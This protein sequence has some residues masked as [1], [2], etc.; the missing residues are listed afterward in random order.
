MD[1]SGHIRFEDRRYRVCVGKESIESLIESGG[2]RDKDPELNDKLFPIVQDSS[3]SVTVEIQIV[4]VSGAVDR[5]T[6]MRVLRVWNLR[7]V[8][9]EEFLSLFVQHESVGRDGMKI[10]ALGSEALV[11]GRRVFPCVN[12]YAP[13]RDLI[14][15][16][17]EHWYRYRESDLCFAVVEEKEVSSLRAYRT[18]DEVETREL[19][20]V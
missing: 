2:F 11:R 1:G 15:V 16:Y 19:V 18:H 8:R 20:A 17:S 9:I 7:P 4:S 3:R 10:F 13:D 14:I 5:D 6:V 12:V